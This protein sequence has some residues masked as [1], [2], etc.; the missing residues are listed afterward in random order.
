MTLASP[1]DKI[2]HVVPGFSPRPNSERGQKPAT[3]YLISAI[4][5]V[6]L[7]LSLPKPD[8]YPLAWI[9]LG[10]LIFA[11]AKAKSVAQTVLASYIA[12]VVFFSGTFYWITETMT[13]YGGL[14]VPLSVGVG[15]LFALMYAL[16]FVLFALGL[17]LALHKFGAAG[18]FF[19]AP[20]WVTVEWLR[21]ILF[22]GFPWMLSGYSLVPYAGI[23][24]MVAWTGIYGLSFLAAF[25]SSLIA[26]ALL[27][28][29]QA[30]AAVAGAIVLVSWFLPVLGRTPSGDPVAV[31]LVQTNIPL[32]Q[33]WQKPDSDQLLDELGALSTRDTAKPKLVVWPETPA[34]FYLSDTGFRTRMQNMARKLGAYFL[35]GYIDAKGDEPSN[36]AALLNPQGDQVSRYDKM[37]LV[38]FG[39]YV[40]F[41]NLLFFASS[42]TREVG[43]FVP[44]TDYTISPMDGHPISTAICY[45]SIFPDLVRQ[46]VKKGSELIVVITND[47]WFGQSSAPYQHLRMGVVRSVENHR[48][49]V[50]TANTGISAI[51]DPYGKIESET[52]IGERMILDGSAQFRTDRTFYTEYGDVFAYLN[53][54]AAIILLAW[55]SNA[56]RAY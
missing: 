41:K 30:A 55:R 24:Q 35:I 11:I 49:M 50:R 42:L 44:G 48:W 10:P 15:A 53:V 46:F 33:P 34:P 7:V 51:I 25:V 54:L 21:S 16:Y 45:E 6:L 8:L 39:E 32:D 43:E 27:Q 20:V 52:P 12:G 18:L 56:R 22:S 2:G 17:H 14:S 31:R 38:P 3:T 28:R 9:A 5:G 23:L 29:S 1:P 19:A 36:S 40:P 13:I 26:Y 37:H 4:S 47:G